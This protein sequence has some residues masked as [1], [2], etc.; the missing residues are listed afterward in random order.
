MPSTT[1][2]PLQFTSVVNF[3]YPDVYQRVLDGLD[4]FNFD[5]SWI[6]S[7][8]CVFDIDFHDRLLM[9]TIGPIVALLCLALTY[10]ITARI[11]R[12]APDTIQIIRNKHV[13]LVLLLTFLVYASV[14]SVLFMS[15]ACEDLEDGKNYLRA[16]Y[17]IECDSAR[18]RGFQVYAG[19]MVV[20]YTAGIP[21]FYGVLLFRGREILRGDQ[22]D[23]E[24]TAWLASISDLW[25][26]YKRSVYYYE[27]IECGRR[28]LL[29]GVVV[30]IYP[31]TAAQIA[32]TLL[33]AFVFV[34][35]SEVLAPYESRWDAWLSRIGHAVVYVSMYDALLLKVDVSRERAGS[36]KAFEGLLVT[37]HAC[38]VLVVV[39]ETILL[40][41][42]LRVDRREEE[43]A[44]GFRP[45]K[46]SFRGKRAER[47]ALANPF[48]AD[49]YEV[50]LPPIG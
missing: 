16:D 2:I 34:V 32:V 14:S 39:V 6:L 49:I 48:A 4:V 26:P 36:Q 22:T 10:S 18:H 37:A 45:G 11:N 15:F 28:V 30:F 1:R 25:K 13:S 12:A 8:G 23:R 31:N 44:R 17:R 19:F 47:E 27:V 3:A 29:T 42:V 38:M 33:M 40:T 7:V 50:E 43:P 35:V 46:A 41:C 20:L 24:E 21:A 9:V 5:L